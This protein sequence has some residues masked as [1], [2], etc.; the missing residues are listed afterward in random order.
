MI[1]SQSAGSF[2][3]ITIWNHVRAILLLPFMNTVVIPVL[4]LRYFDDARLG[5]S[6]LVTDT[7]AAFLSIPILAAG[8]VL[9]VRAISLFVTR[10]EGTLAP[11]DPAQVLLA[12]DIYRLSRNPMKTG[13]FLIL[14]GECVLFRAPSLMIW[15]AAFMTVNALYIMWSEEPGLRRRFG[16]AY[17]AYCSHVPRWIGWSAYRNLHLDT[18]QL[19]IKERLS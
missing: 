12:E 3:R 18:E 14:I 8:M 6:T 9:A 5:Q 17:A 11:W 2:R 1:K 16:P 10:G 13:L 7:W 4:L 15:T 19:N